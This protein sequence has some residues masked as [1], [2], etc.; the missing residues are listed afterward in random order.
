MSQKGKNQT[1]PDFQALFLAVDDQQEKA[2]TQFFASTALMAILCHYDRAL[3]VVN[4]WSAGEKQHYVLVLLEILFQH[5]P[6]Q[7]V[8]GLL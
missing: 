6:P 2:S 7:F 5:L 3:W 4:M 1:G 8:I